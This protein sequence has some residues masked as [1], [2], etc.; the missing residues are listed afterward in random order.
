[1]WE[2]LGYSLVDRQGTVK[3]AYRDYVRRAGL[4]SWHRG[5]RPDVGAARGVRRPVYL[6]D[7]EGLGLGSVAGLAVGASALG[8][9][10]MGAAA[11]GALALAAFNE[12][13]K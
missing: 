6:Q 12:F 7:D 13:W 4:R 11:C 3:R 9:L 10:G 5:R 8:V 1:M 2:R